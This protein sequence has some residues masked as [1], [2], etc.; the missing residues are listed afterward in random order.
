MNNKKKKKKAQLPF[1]L[2][3][4]FFVVF[5]LFSVLVLQL[6]VVQI[7]NGEGFQKEI[8]RTI[9]DTTKIPVPRG[10][11]YDRNGNV[12]VDNKPLYAITYTP[13]KG[14]DATKR[15]EVAEKL[16]EYISMYN[17]E[18]KEEVLET[19]TERNK[20]EYWYLLHQEEAK[21]RLSAKEAE[22]MEPAE[23]YNTILDRITKEE[24][25]NFSDKDKEIMLIKKELDKAQTL[26]PQ[27]V[28]NENVTPEEYARVAEHL[29]ELEGINATTDWD[30]IYPF[31]ETFSN[32]FGTITSQEQGILAEKEEYYLSHGYK[33]N[34]RVGKSGLEEQYENVL[35]G[36]KEQILYTTNKEGKI[37]D[38]EVAVEGERGKDLV[39]TVDMELQKRIDKIVLD[40]LKNEKSEHPY[41]NRHLNDAMVVMMRPQTGEILAVS[42]KYYDEED[43]EYK[44]AALRT[45]YSSHR[46]GSAIKGATVL[47]GLQS[48]VIKP[49]KTFVD[50]PIYIGKNSDGKTSWTGNLGAVNDITAL[51]KS[52]N[53]Y[54]F[55]IAMRMGGDFNYV[56]Y[57]NLSFD[58]ESKPFQRL[59]NYYSQFGL[60]V[61]TGIDFP[62]E[63]SGYK[64]VNPQ[65]GN[66]LDFAIGQYDTF[67]AMQLAQYVSTIANDGYRVR[68]HLVKEIRMPTPYENNLGP[69]YKSINTDV[70]NRIDMKQSYIERVQ[71]GFRRAFQEPGGTAY[72]WFS[73]KD[74]NPAGKTGTAEN[75][76]EGDYTENLTLV[77]YAPF[78][79]PEI[80]F[81]VIVPNTGGSKYGHPNDDIGERILDAYFDLK[82]E[83]AKSSDNDNSDKKD[84]KTEE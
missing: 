30:R 70:L 57:D 71:E 68:P 83:R 36:R 49:N 55:Y 74:Y 54:M 25:S 84:E 44:N 8:D 39:L 16:S 59:R 60:G 10:K 11:M 6:G 29:S 9:K 77:G 58:W 18:N 35:R 56:P 5:L 73:D 42:G 72:S 62:Y 24:I 64:G 46:P 78:D 43:K 63:A 81:S 50:K 48:G 37:I 45:L 19:I 31:D 33:P 38:S 15:L 4:L 52:S 34:D 22:G 53:V 67:T 14:V 1:R 27:V 79:K 23:Q 3:I 80:A 82:E 69:V 76:A 12:V 2:N 66:F 32:F 13:A 26:T 7:L 65:A 51:Q 47:A 41:G 61:K 20:K 21:D 40:V 75:S 17:K 28:K